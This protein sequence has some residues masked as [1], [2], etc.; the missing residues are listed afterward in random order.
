MILRP[1]STRLSRLLVPTLSLML[2][3]CVT[4]IAQ[5]ATEPAIPASSPSAIETPI[6]S[7]TTADTVGTAPTLA[8][9]LVSALDTNPGVL[10]AEDET[11]ASKQRL[12]RANSN[13]L[14]RL[15]AEETFT[16]FRHTSEIMGRPL[17][18]EQ[19][20]L[21]GIKLSQ[22]IYTGGALENGVNA[23]RAGVN[24]QKHAETRRREDMVRSVAEAWFGLLSARAME[25]VASQALFDTLGHER[26]VQ[27]MLEAGVAVR[28]D[29]LKVQVSVLERRENLVKARNGID[30]AKARLEMLTGL[31]IE[32]TAI[33][34]PANPDTTPELS[35]EHAVSLATRSHPLLRAAREAVRI[36]DFSA[37]AAKGALLPNVALQWNWSSGNQFNTAQDNW[38]ATVYVGLNVFDAG[39]T[40]SKVREAR[41]AKSKATHDLE[42][43]ERN[44]LLA[45]HQ[46]FLRIEEA[47]ARLELSTQAE[48]QAAESLRLTEERFKAGAVTSQH[49]LDAE[50]ALVSARQRRVTAGF[51]QALARIA[52]WHA[53]GG[54]EHALLP[55]K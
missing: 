1:H 37:K 49:L 12:N 20:Q 7:A 17:G 13:L 22:P 25:E 55:L 24:I 34:V 4:G 40:R 9:C 47:R 28:D 38:D 27:N 16:N 6:G 26:H 36:Q 35:E 43:L 21:K 5:T 18:K 46:A 15:K 29:L 2:F 51:D 44:I 39:E 8:E 11:R 45:I 52:L 10:S 19:L 50:S 32:P 30:L 48:A 3:T 14:P 41:A 53:A 42:D 54:L 31:P 23:A 33:P